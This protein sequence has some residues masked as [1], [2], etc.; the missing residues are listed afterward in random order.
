MLNLRGEHI[1]LRAIEPQDLEVLYK[2]EN[3]TDIW[4][5]SGTNSPYSKHVLKLYLDNAH[6]DIYD[7]KQLRLCICNFDGKVVGLIDLF[8]FDPKNHRAGLGI[9][10]LDTANRNKGIGTEAISLLC[11]YSFSTLQLKQ[12]YANILE[13][14]KSSV[15]LFEKLGFKLVGL[16]KDWIYSDETYKNE[17][18]YQKIKH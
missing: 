10:V 7:V 1:Y 14:N 16:K 18:L 5:I 3:D 2:L 13:D 11:E 8:D 17:L 6:R 15:H 9:I 4:E 12:L